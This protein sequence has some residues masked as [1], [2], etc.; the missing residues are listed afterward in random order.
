[1]VIRETK[2]I[3]PTEWVSFP[4]NL[5]LII[6]SLL[7]KSV[8]NLPKVFAEQLRSAMKG[9]GTDGELSFFFF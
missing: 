4:P 6:V 3:K 9:A 1:M 8:T 7:V 5:I 2:V